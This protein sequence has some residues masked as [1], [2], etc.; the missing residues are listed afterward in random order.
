VKILKYEFALR[1]IHDINWHTQEDLVKYF[2]FSKI[3]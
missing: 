2:G 1:K 3:S